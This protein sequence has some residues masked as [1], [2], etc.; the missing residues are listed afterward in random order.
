MCQQCTSIMYI[1]HVHQPCISTLYKYNQQ[2]VPIM[3]QQ[4]TKLCLN[5]MHQDHHVFQV[6]MS[7]I[8]PIIYL[9]HIPITYTKIIKKIPLTMHHTLDKSNTINP[10]IIHVPQPHC[11]KTSICTNNFNTIPQLK[12][13]K[14]EPILNFSRSDLDQLYNKP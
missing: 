1:N 14:H 9:Y 13:L 2:H 11:Y 7:S 6:C 5:K 12:S 10:H 4:Q 3:Y 8:Y